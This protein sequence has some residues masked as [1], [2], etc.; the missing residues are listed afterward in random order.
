MLVNVKLEDLTVE[1]VAT[2][3]RRYRH[4]GEL[5]QA[6]ELEA[7]SDLIRE[8]WSLSRPR[9][10][11]GH[12]AAGA[13]APSCGVR[14]ARPPG[15]ID[16]IGHR[17][18]GLPTGQSEERGGRAMN[19]PMREPIEVVLIRERRRKRLRRV[20]RGLSPD[21]QYDAPRR[22]LEEVPDLAEQMEDT[23]L[24]FWAMCEREQESK[25]PHL[26]LVKL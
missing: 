22:V 13:Q 4:V 16:L 26:R 18:A 14:P 20:L 23:Y 2:L 3:V 10:D 9:W 19:E 17:T 24:E 12:V 7:V 1:D 25:R 6:A 8:P 11:E 21:D 5:E 15:R